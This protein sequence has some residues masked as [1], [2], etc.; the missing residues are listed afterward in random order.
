MRISQ[1]KSDSVFQTGPLLLPDKSPSV[2]FV[3]CS[4]FVQA[5]RRLRQLGE[6]DQDEKNR[7]IMVL[8]A[9]VQRGS[10]AE[11]NRFVMTCVRN[12][13]QKFNVELPP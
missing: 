13:F 3:I 10:L 12:A 8:D 1:G 2:P 11:P 7:F 5:I 6:L 9:K 4:E